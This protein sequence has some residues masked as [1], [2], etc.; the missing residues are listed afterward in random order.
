[1]PSSGRRGGPFPP[2]QRQPAPRLLPSGTRRLTG[3]FVVAV[4]WRWQVRQRLQK[5]QERRAQSERNRRE[6]VC[7]PRAPAL[8]LR[9]VIPNPADLSFFI[10]KLRSPQALLDPR[11]AAHSSPSASASSVYQPVR[12]RRGRMEGSPDAGEA[13][14]ADV[15]EYY[16]GPA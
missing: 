4:G 5:K 9:L 11:V 10:H 2:P 7:A 6:T 3:V 14:T 15:D 12:G 13:P 16:Y 8:P 1:M